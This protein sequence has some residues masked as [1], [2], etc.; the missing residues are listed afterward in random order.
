MDSEIKLKHKLAS[1]SGFKTQGK[2]L[3]AIQ[4]CEQLLNEYPNN[5]DVHFELAELY[6]L[7]GNLNSTFNILEAYL[8]NNP[9]DQDIRLFFGQ[10]L[11]K[12]HVWEKAIKVFSQFVPEE[13]PLALFFLGHAYFMI[14]D[15]E[16]ARISFLGFLSLEANR[17]LAFEAYISLAKIEIEMKD[18]EQAL[19]YAK[20][21]ELFYSSHWEL[22]FIY[23]KCYFQ[24][25]MDAHAVLAI[26]KAM[27]LN[28]KTVL[29][30]EWA[31]KIF[32][33]T[34]EYP[35]AENYLM[36]FIE[37]NELASADIY[38]Q[39]ADACMKSNKIESALSYYEQALKIDPSNKYALTG[40][41]N[42]SGNNKSPLTKDV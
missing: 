27:K 19:M 33:R 8:E 26:E 2:Y 20:Q 22:H 35:K 37:S 17:E 9:K 40:M 25:G 42:I 5:A 12:H 21:S 36:K 29:P 1:V 11:F 14:K 28:P 6:E 13:K 16:M 38:S 7:S 31:G 24:L 41:Q 3:H 23:A 39:L 30:Y 15:F 10:L 18:F 4:I 32:L 34:G